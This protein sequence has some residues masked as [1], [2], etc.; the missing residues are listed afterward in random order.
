[1]PGTKQGKMNDVV[2]LMATD[3]IVGP[4]PHLSKLVSGMP[5]HIYYRGC[6]TKNPFPRLLAAGV[7]I[8]I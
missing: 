8:V 7:L 3:V 6:K 2:I 1:M 5:S 4:V